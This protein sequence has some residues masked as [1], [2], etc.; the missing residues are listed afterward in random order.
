M[1]AL[2]RASSAMAERFRHGAFLF[3][4]GGRAVANDVD[5]LTVEFVH[6]VT[7][8]ARAIGA[9]AAVA[10]DARNAADAVRTLAR[11]G[12]VCL[13]IAERS[14]DPVLSRALAAAHYYGLTT[15]GLVSARADSP[16]DVAPDH[17]VVAGSAEKESLVVAHHALWEMVQVALASAPVAA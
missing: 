13:A 17:L 16:P 2:E 6:P 7:D 12:D 9:F 1:E 4:I 5:D 11:D 14:D 8:G 10:D 3:V 15:V